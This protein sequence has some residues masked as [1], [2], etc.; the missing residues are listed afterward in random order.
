V[1]NQFTGS[2]IWFNDR[3]GGFTDSG[4]ELGTFSDDARS[5]GLEDL[6]GDG[7]LDLYI[8]HAG[9][10]ANEIWL[11]DGS[12]FFTNSGQAIGGSN[13]IDVELADLDGDGD[14]DAF[15]ANYGQP[16]RVWLNNGSGTFEF[17]GQA[18]GSFDSYGVQLAD[19]DNDGDLDAFVATRDG[20]DHV[21]FNDGNA[22]FT[23][24]SQ[25]IG[26]TDSRAV[27]AGDLDGDSDIDVFVATYGGSNK[28]W[29]NNG[30]GS[31]TEGSQ[32][33]VAGDAMDVAL[34]DLDGDGDLDA[35]VIDNFAF[36]KVLFNDGTGS[37]S[38]SGQAIG[39]AYSQ[40][41][42]VIDV[43]LDGDLDIVIGGPGATQVWL[44]DGNGSF[45]EGTTTFGFAN[46]KNVVLGDVDDDGQGLIFE[47]DTVTI[48]A[49]V[50]LDND[51][52]IDNGASLSV[53]GVSIPGVG[54]GSL[55]LDTPTVTLSA[56]EVIYDPHAAFD[57][58]AV[59]ESA[60][61]TF[62]YTITDEFGGT[63]VAQ[64]TLTI[65]GENDEPVAFGDEGT[66]T[67][68]DGV[69][70][71]LLGND[72]DVD[73]SDQLRIISVGPAIGNII[74]GS[75]QI[76]YDANGH[77]ESL[78]A[79]TTATDIFSYTI[80]DGHGVGS[81]STADVTV[82]ILGENDA[83]T[84]VDDSGTVSE[85]GTVSIA[86]L[87]NDSD[88]DA[89]TTLSGHVSGVD[90]PIGDA[91]V[92]D[93]VLI[94]DPNGQF[95]DLNNGETAIDVFSYTLTDGDGGT[96]IAQVTVTINGSEATAPVAGDDTGE[97]SESLPFTI[98]VLSNDSDANDD[99]LTITQ[100]DSLAPLSGSVSI[101]NGEIVYDPNG[102][103]DGLGLGS[104]ATESFSYTIDDGTGLTDTATVDVTIH[105]HAN[106]SSAADSITGTDFADLI[107]GGLGNDTINGG[108]G[109]DQ[110]FGGADNDLINGGDGADRIEGGA[111][112][113]ILSG[114]GADLDVD[115]FVFN[116]G[117]ALESAGIITTERITDFESGFD[118]ID[119]TSFA[120]ANGFADLGISE[121]DGR[122][123]IE[124]DADDKI[125]VIGV[126][127]MT[128]D[129]FL[130]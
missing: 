119:L 19:L 7:D 25:N 11:N 36:D 26:N 104:T 20:A 57:F 125:V 28:I 34:A 6:D 50:L 129:D 31:F 130:F 10:Q 70:I 124:F 113:D 89:G 75:S 33:F 49:A 44:N 72:V 110:L 108:N 91:T 43:D 12:G 93:G 98:D 8:G 90:A 87:D 48:S 37:F 74:I 85:T 86:I 123:T 40:A 66:V 21:W 13:T 68:N 51:T 126:T 32:S 4:Q 3:S 5:A 22:S 83:P 47:N 82:T 118:L 60:T 39:S 100:I 16:D 81:T 78:A 117:D 67:E 1:I 128:E 65:T 27:A 88:P 101:V 64:V 18:L 127:G 114:G 69:F 56:G 73:A 29:L 95:D 77:F 24:S 41:V 2:E 120:L 112:V 14:F 58:L 71:E 30:N 99:T 115:I 9:Y 106:G 54:P 15:E 38:D 79:G 122:T 17:N 61:T 62:N 76:L 42:D 23:L 105:G 102:A 52:D 92:V 121:A 107:D 111:G 59:G 80:Y 53:I 84:A 55:D 35:V 63:D 97:G 116:N 109:D 46:T 96:D 45:S 94:Y 103:F